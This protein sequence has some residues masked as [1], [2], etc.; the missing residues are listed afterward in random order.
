MISIKAHGCTL[1]AGLFSGRRFALMRVFFLGLLCA[2]AL[3]APAAAQP[4]GATATALTDTSDAPA[5]L[6]IEADG[7]VRRIRGVFA[8]G[9]ARSGRLAYRLVVEEGEAGRSASHQSGTFE[10]QPGRP[11][12]LATASVGVQP[13][14]RLSAR[15]SVSDAGRVVGEGLRYRHRLFCSVS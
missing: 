14:D 9:E 2:A 10:A 12:T 13:G 3:A 5:R 1:R 15:L 8:D 7:P 11:D 4:C 6:P